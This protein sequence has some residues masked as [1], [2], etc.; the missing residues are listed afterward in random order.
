MYLYIKKENKYISEFIAHYKNYGVDKIYLYDNNEVN[1]ER[2]EKTIDVH[3]SQGLIEIINYRGKQSIIYKVMNDCYYENN[4]NYDWLIFYELD[5]FISLYN[6]TNINQLIKEIKFA[7][8][9]IYK[10]NYSYW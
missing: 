8:Y 6:Y 2:F 3:I 9:Q 5:E 7:Q 4:N 1:G 10:F